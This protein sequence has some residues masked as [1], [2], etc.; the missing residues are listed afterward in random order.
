MQNR[1]AKL[2]PLTLLAL[3][4]F[5]VLLPVSGQ[6]QSTALKTGKLVDSETGT[7]TTNQIILIEGPTIKAIG[8]DLKIPE[9]AVVIDLS[10][11]TV[12]H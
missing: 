11:Q 8:A 4:S 9:N 2:L 5:I 10:R 6:A 12:L 3:I 7:V 1:I